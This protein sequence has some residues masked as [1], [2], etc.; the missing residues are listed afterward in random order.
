MSRRFLFIAVLLASSL[1]LDAQTP[2]QAWTTIAPDQCVF[3]AGD[4]PAWAAP[5]FDDSAWQPYSSWKIDVHTRRIW[6]RCHANLAPLRTLDHPALQV[7]LDAAS[8]LYLNGALIGSSGDVATG[9]SNLRLICT[10]PLAPAT[11]TPSSTLALR[12]TLRTMEQTDRAQILIGDEQALRD[13]RAAAALS[14]ALGFLPVALCFSLIGVVGFML[15]G[16]WV[17]DRTRLELLLLAIVCWLLCDLRL[18]EFC[19][20][21]LVPMPAALYNVL[22]ASGQ[23]LLIP[24]LPFVF[25]IA[26]KRVPWIYWVAVAIATTFFVGGLVSNAFLPAALNLREDALY[27]LLS[28][29][30]FPAAMA[31]S[32]APLVAFWPLHRI[33]RRLRAVAFFC[34]AWGGA[35]FLWFS[36]WE[37][38]IAGVLNFDQATHL[39]KY[40]LI[41]RAATTLCSV[42]ALL[43]ILFREQRRIAQDRALLAGEMQAARE[44]QS[45]LAPATLET[46]PGLHVDV[47]FH[48]MRDVGGDFYLCRPLPD[49][50]QRI[51]VGDVSGKGTAAA[52]T[53]TLLIGAAERRDA[54]SPAAL[55]QHLNSVLR[56]SRVGGFATCLCVDVAHDGTVTLANAGHLP[57]YSRGQEIPILS[58]LPLGVNAPGEP[59]Y[60]ETHY[61]LQPGDTLTFLSDGVVEAQNPAGQLFGFDRARAISR[62]SAE[63]IARAASTHGQSDDI[64]VLTLQYAPAGVPIA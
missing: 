19:V 52:M 45:L 64:T 53:A 34:I 3:H 17:T 13:H 6:V 42:L 7:R 46:I 12:I 48:P 10:V 37:S 50:R 29:Y 18:T 54:D 9:Q 35:D 40:L 51:L 25:R 11:L 8:A 63:E 56:N 31:C 60:E 47:A 14:G 41:L 36:S 59:A 32:T 22:Y 33:P 28:G 4:D 55:L 26:G 5:S 2:A 58:A 43:T 61:A 62:E 39:Q 44:I 16:L 49:G 20:N 30:I 24:W 57:P 23:F 15:L 21:A 27:N 1:T 38:V